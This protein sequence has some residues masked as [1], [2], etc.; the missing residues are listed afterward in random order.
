[1]RQFYFLGAKSSCLPCNLNTALVSYKTISFYLQKLPGLEINF[2]LRDRDHDGSRPRPRSARKSQN[3]DRYPEHKKSVSRP[4]ALV[5]IVITS[6]LIHFF[7]QNT[8]R[9]NEPFGL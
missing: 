6:F 9:I 2:K 7:P 8:L 5:S 1:M 4:T 3:Q